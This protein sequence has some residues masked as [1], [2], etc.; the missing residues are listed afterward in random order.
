[1]PIDLCLEIKL[2]QALIFHYIIIML[3]YSNHIL[4]LE[5]MLFFPV[6]RECNLQP[7]SS[8]T[9]CPLSCL[10]SSSSALGYSA[11]L[12]VV[13]VLLIVSLIGNIVLV[14]GWVLKRH[15]FDSK[16]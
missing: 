14:I 5:S 3:L 16:K 10:Q 15:S 12:G 2:V 13:S 8:P 9:S 7:S 11:G 6:P 1:M 4:L